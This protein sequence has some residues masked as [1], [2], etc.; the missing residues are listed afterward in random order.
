MIIVH[1]HVH[2]K[3]EFIDSFKEAS[4]ENARNS[5]HEPGIIRFDV[6]QQA[7]DP[8]RF[9]LIEIYRNELAQGEHKQTSH[10]AQWRDTVS[11]MMAEPRSSVKYQ[12]IFPVEMG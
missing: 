4:I 6:V 2:V 11:E 7:D 5:I 8:T 3:D 9:V 10:Y 12:A 1:V